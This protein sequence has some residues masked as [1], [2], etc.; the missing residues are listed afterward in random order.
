MMESMD[1]GVGLVLQALDDAK[2]ADNTVVIFTSDNGGVS[3]GDGYATSSLPFRGGKGRQWEGGIREPF[4]IYWPGVTNGADNTGANNP[5]PVSHIDFFPTL[6]EMAG[7][8]PTVYAGVD[9]VSLVPALRGKSLPERNLFWHYPH[10][11]NQGGEPSA[12]MRS[13]DWKLIHYFEDGHNELYNIGLDVGEQ[14]DMAAAEPNRTASMLAELKRW[15]QSVGAIDPTPNPSFDAAKRE[16]E[17][18]QQR[19]VAM[20]NREREHASYLLPDFVPRGGWWQEKAM[21][22]G[23]Q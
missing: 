12:I 10:Y 1:A 19:E 21:K 15:Q 23:E 6:M 8:K 5:T 13:G 16:M 3:S 14:N 11:G 9:G 17:L 4:Y 20:A 18:K 22:A 2:L 7:V